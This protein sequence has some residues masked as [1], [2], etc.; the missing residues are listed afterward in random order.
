MDNPGPGHDSV[1]N[2][3]SLSFLAASALNANF[4]RMC[5]VP[6]SLNKPLIVLFRPIEVQSPYC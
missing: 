2:L 5:T 1:S 4:A 6:P 3:R